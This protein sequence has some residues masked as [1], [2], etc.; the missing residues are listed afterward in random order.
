MEFNCDEKLFDL[1]LNS[2]PASVNKNKVKVKEA[3]V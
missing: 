2:P 1:E 3:F